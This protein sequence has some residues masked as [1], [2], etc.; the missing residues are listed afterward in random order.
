M[1][2]DLTG[3]VGVVTGGNGGIGLGIA[4]G[5]ALAG[6]D[7]AIWSRNE[8]KTARAIDHLREL[9]PGRRFFGIACDVAS[10]DSVEAAT[11]ATIAELGRID[12]CVANA[13]TSGNVPFL[14][15]TLEEWR[16][17]TATNLDGV[18]LTIQAAAKQMVA[19]GEGGAL[20][21]VS[22]TSAIHG[23]PMTSHYASAKTGCLA[24]ARSAAVALARHKIRVNSLMPGWTITELASGLYENDRFREVTISRTPARR[25]ADP[26]EF[27][28]VG[29][30]LCDKR[31]TYH[32]GDTVTVDG[33][34]TVF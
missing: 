9:A 32:T 3:Q 30:Y 19:Q 22:S 1:S 10:Q 20:V 27:R 11:A 16:R 26:V 34:Y 7:V 33:G 18:F 17:V 23:A 28:E 15:M 25:W 24:L 13:G 21:V 29:A 5:L 6:A 12:A 4:E 14:E 8:E 31:L 2:V